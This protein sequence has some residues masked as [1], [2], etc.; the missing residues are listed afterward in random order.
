MGNIKKKKNTALKKKEYIK[1]SVKYF[2]E[3]GYEKANMSKLAK[4]LDVSVGTLYKV[5][6]NKE[7]L[8]LE[9]I[10]YQID[11]FSQVLEKNQTKDPM[12]NLKIYL[13]HKYNYFMANKKSIELSLAYDPFFVHKLSI[14][15]GHPMDKIFKFLA[16]Q[17]KEILKDDKR[18]YIHISILF[19]KL[20]DGYAESF[21]I[22]K[23][24]TSNIIDDTIDLFLNGLLQHTK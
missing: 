12:S 14:D 24:D 21:K 20:S 4:I 1:D 19:K 8:Y 5:F 15:K 10:L 2:Q 17:F 22:K 16:K 11:S 23:F 6:V 18:D 9:F 7:N 3:V 13:E